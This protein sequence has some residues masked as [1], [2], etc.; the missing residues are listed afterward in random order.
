MNQLHIACKLKT[1]SVFSKINYYTLSCWMVIL[2]SIIFCKD[3]CNQ[4]SEICIYSWKVRF[5]SLNRGL[6][7]SLISEDLFVNLWLIYLDFLYDPLHFWINSK[8]INILSDRICIKSSCCRSLKLLI[9]LLFH[10]KLC[11]LFSVLLDLYY[12][13]KSNF[14][15]DTDSSR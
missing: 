12:L 15:Y 10:Q 4:C 13:Y 8:K 9:I 14:N 11:F 6:N 7:S 1:S 2:S 3:F 5:L